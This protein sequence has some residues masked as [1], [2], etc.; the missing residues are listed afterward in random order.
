MEPGIFF[1]LHLKAFDILQLGSIR[2]ASF[3]W[4]PLCTACSARTISGP[5]WWFCLPAGER[6]GVTIAWKVASQLGGERLAKPATW[7][8]G[9]VSRSNPAG[10]S[11]MREPYL[12]TF[13]ACR[14]GVCSIGRQKGIRRPG[15][16]WRAGCLLAAIYPSMAVFALIG[17]IGWSLLRGLHLKISWR[18]ALIAAVVTIVALVLTA[19]SLTRVH[20]AGRSLPVVLTSWFATVRPMD[21]YV[22]QRSSGWIQAFSGTARAVCICLLWLVMGLHNQSYRRPS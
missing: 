1:R 15:S 6:H 19:W 13:I 4:T 2:R 11:E 22:L 16:G 20:W 9:F 21:V 18:T 8:I 17:M 7:V 3:F 10:A 12:M 5:G 14:S